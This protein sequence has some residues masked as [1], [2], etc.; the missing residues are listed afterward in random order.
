MHEERIREAM[1]NP[2][3]ELNTLRR[4]TAQAYY[5]IKTSKPLL[6]TLRTNQTA[7]FLRLQ[8]AAM[9]LRKHGDPRKG[10]F[11]GPTLNQ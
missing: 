8:A 2:S 6:V 5:L 10:G 11:S 4:F 1:I 7:S 3:T 9:R